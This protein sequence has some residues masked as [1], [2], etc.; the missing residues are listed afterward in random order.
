MGKQCQRQDHVIYQ[1]ETWG[2][3]KQ[4]CTHDQPGQDEAEP[5]LI[6]SRP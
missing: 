3:D 4:R 6:L 2:G 1:A 5:A